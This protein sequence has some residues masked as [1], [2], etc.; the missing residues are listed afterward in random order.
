MVLHCDKGR[1]KELQW[2]FDDFLM[3]N[4]LREIMTL[5]RII[6]LI[7]AIQHT[8]HLSPYVFQWRPE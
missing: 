4:G 5:Y 7:E 1:I 2:D 6:M 8:Q 3:F